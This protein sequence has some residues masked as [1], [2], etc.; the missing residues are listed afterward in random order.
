MAAFEKKLLLE[1]RMFH[2]HDYGRK[3]SFFWYFSNTRLNCIWPSWQHFTNPDFTENTGVPFPETSATF[4]GEV[5][6][7]G[8][9]LTLPVDALQPFFAGPFHGFCFPIVEPQRQNTCF[10]KTLFFKCCTSL[11]THKCKQWIHIIT[12]HIDMFMF[13]LYI[14]V[15][16]HIFIHT[17]IYSHVHVYKNMNENEHLWIY[18]AD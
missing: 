17:M 16:I 7:G 4:E 5:M 11:Y 14:Y 6:W 1:E 13:Q 18:P 8:Y 10:H 2:F 9:T 15:N 3:G 12:Q